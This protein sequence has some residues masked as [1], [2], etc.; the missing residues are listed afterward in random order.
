MKIF[1]E[2]NLL[3]NESIKNPQRFRECMLLY[4]FYATAKIKIGRGSS[5]NHYLR[6]YDIRELSLKYLNSL[7]LNI[8]L[9][10]NKFIL[11]YFNS[12]NRLGIDEEDKMIAIS[13]LE[14]LAEEGRLDN[15]N[16]QLLINTY[17]SCEKGV[18]KHLKTCRLL[19]QYKL[20]DEAINEA[21]K[22]IALDAKNWEGYSVLGQFYE[23]KGMIQKAKRAYFDA[24]ICKGPEKDCILAIARCNRLL[25]RKESI[26]SSYLFNQT[27]MANYS[28]FID[29]FKILYESNYL[30]EAAN[31]AKQAIQNDPENWEG[32]F[33]L[34]QCYEKMKEYSEAC[35]AYSMALALEGPK[36]ECLIALANCSNFLGNY[37]EAKGYLE[38]ALVLAPSDPHILFWLGLAYTYSNQIQK[39]LTIYQKLN[40]LDKNLAVQLFDNIYK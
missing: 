26:V 31:A 35:K 38:K 40:L 39:S 2:K 20:L 37:S 32:H 10:S 18:E 36:K 19:Y 33:S 22:I 14:K 24:L 11:K 30:D 4:Y 5:A 25:D 17:Y 16:I 27:T 34:G 7:K 3:E 12:L 29:A 8:E 9:E 15:E 23:Q 13:K 6:R 1:A 21:H 28:G